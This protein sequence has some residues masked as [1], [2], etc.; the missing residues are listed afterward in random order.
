M[1][2][3]YILILALVL[4]VGML[5]GCG[6]RNSKPLNTESTTMPRP[7]TTA[8]TTAAT[9]APTTEATQFTDATNNTID[10]GNGPLPTD[11]TVTPGENSRSNS[12]PRSK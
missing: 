9:T 1:K 7:E 6:C 10:N 8:P 4:T 3:F 2:K 12:I 11:A 5:T